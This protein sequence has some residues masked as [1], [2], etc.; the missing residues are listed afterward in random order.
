MVTVPAVEK[1][2]SKA[3]RN[4]RSRSP[5]PRIGVVALSVAVDALIFFS[6]FVVI[7]L[8]RFERGPLLHF[9][10]NLS[11]RDLMERP[12][13]QDHFALAGIMGLFFLILMHKTGVYNASHRSSFVPEFARLVNVVFL[14]LV[15][16]VVMSSFIGRFVISRIVLFGSQALLLPTLTCWRFVR[17]RQIERLLTRGYQRRIALVVGAGKVGR[18]L[19]SFLADYP[20]FG[21]AVIGF[22][23]DRLGNP[24]PSGD[25][26]LSVPILGAVSDFKTVAVKE[27]VNYIYITIPSERSKIA[28]LV[29][30]AYDLGITV[31]VVP[32]LFDLLV[33]EVEFGTVGSLPVLRLLRPTLSGWEK[34]LKRVE[35]LVIASVMLLVFAPVMALIALAIKLDSAGPIIYWQRRHG[36]YGRLFGLYKFRSMYA[37]ADETKHRVAAQKWMTSSEPLD[38]QRKLYKLTEDDRVTRV[39][40]WIRKSNLDE[41]P[42]LWNVLRGQMSLV[43]PR[44]PV[45]YEYEEYEKYHRKRLL[46]KPG[47]TG[48][49]QVSGLHKLSFEEMVLLDIRYINE[50]SVWMDLWIIGKTIPLLLFGRGA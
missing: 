48:L 21:V 13:F 30:D 7:Y 49:W 4:D 46:S 16:G 8:L 32:E 3:P 20:T 47:I 14:T 26:T 17:H 2:A 43:G 45:P 42:Q 41:L 12:Y 31:H 44:P 28:G 15:F 36:Q 35:D 18:Y 50:W 5:G 34:F 9:P 1:R 24:G 23:D 27:Q 19:A 29:E 37:D 33:R 10:P 11:C 39:G 25:A 38:K 22:L 40:R 6:V